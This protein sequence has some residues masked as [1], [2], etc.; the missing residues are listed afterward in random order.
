MDVYTH[1]VGFTVEQVNLSAQETREN[2]QRHV[3]I[4][5][6]SLVVPTRVTRLYI[7][8]FSCTTRVSLDIYIYTP[9]DYTTF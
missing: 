6:V 3:V 2:V 1:V 8:E 5:L 7:T 9:C 4:F